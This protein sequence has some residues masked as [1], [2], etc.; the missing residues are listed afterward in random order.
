MSPRPPSLAGR[1]ILAVA[2]MI[3]FYVLALGLA[4][5]LLFIAYAEIVYG[6]TAKDTV[7]LLPSA[8]LVASQDQFKQMMSRASAVPGLKSNAPATPAAGGRRGG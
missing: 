5:I 4:S 8:S 7:M 1:A 2:L 3:G 6:I